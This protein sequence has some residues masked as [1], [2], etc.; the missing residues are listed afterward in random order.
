MAEHS[1]FLDSK[2]GQRQEHRNKVILAWFGVLVGVVGAFATAIAAH[3]GA[4]TPHPP[5]Q[6]PNIVN[7]IKIGFQ[8][9]NGVRIDPGVAMP[10]NFT[11]VGTSQVGKTVSISVPWGEA[12]DT[13]DKAAIVHAAL[14]C[15][16]LPVK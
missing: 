16:D 6:K 2:E 12:S 9:A 8:V 14:G 3:R 4:Q 7:D 1:K 5:D 15:R 11:F 10:I 13:N